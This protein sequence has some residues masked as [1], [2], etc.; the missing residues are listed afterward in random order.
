MEPIPENDQNRQ[1]GSG[2]ADNVEQKMSMKPEINN[3]ERYDSSFV[4]GPGFI[5]FCSWR[6][7]STK[8]T[9]KLKKEAN[10]LAGKADRLY[11]ESAN[12]S[13]KAYKLEKKADKLHEKSDKLNNKADKLAEKAKLYNEAYKL[14]EKADKL[15][16]DESKWH[17]E[18]A[19]EYRRLLMGWVDRF[20]AF[21]QNLS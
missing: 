12:L 20:N 8:K 2:L 11:N 1:G 17:E 15:I 10:K 5:I 14:T 6:W 13:E 3:F 18:H 21:Y 7:K 9:D 16:S 19:K 4:Y